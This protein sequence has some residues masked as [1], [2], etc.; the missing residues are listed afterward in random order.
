MRRVLVSVLSLAGFM[1]PAVADSFLTA[2]SFPKTV[3]D[4]SFKSRMEL[5]SEDYELYRPV[6]DDVTGLC[7][8]NCAY[9][10]FTIK[11][12][13]EKSDRDTEQAVAQSQYYEQTMQSLPVNTQNILASV[14][15]PVTSSSYCANRNTAI[16][17]KQKIPWGEPVQFTP[18]ISSPYGPRKLEGKQSFH[19]GIDYA[20]VVG[21]PVFATADGRVARV[22]NDNTCGKGIRIKHNDGI[23]TIY[24]HLSKQMVQTGDVVNAGCQIGA[25]GNTGHSTGPHLH[26]GMRDAN[27][28]KIDPSRYTKRA[29]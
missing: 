2:Q 13:I 16:P 1:L 23:Q 19:D 26:Y 20:V 7:V 14:S 29:Y 24:C 17:M 10:G 25:S 6:Y 8:E 21:T 9:Y 11:Q 12:E 4:L 15:A 18:R 27:N 3:D 22:I 28:N 5:K